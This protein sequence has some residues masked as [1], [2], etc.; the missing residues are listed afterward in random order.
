MHPTRIFV[1]V[2]T[3]SLL[4]LAPPAAVGQ[5]GQGALQSVGM[6]NVERASPSA[7][8]AARS[9]VAGPDGTGK[10]GP[11]AAVGRELAVLYYQNQTGGKQSVR[12]LREASLSREA[13]PPRTKR[14]RGERRRGGGGRVHSPISA[15]G[16]FVTVEATAARE[17]TRLLGDLEG[18]GL[19]GG[20]TAGNV[21]S[22]RLPISSIRAAAS[23][24]SLRG[25]RPSRAR[26]YVGSAESEADSAHRARST[27][28]NLGVN[29]RGQKVCALSDSY[30][31][32]NSAT[33]TASDD[34][35][36]GDL[37]GAENPSGRTAP[38][39]VLEDYDGSDPEPTDEGRA[40]LQLIHDIAPGARLG[41][42]TAFGGLAGFAQGIRDLA[43]AGC[44]VIVDDVGYSVEP[45]YQDGPVANAVDEVV[46]QGIPYFSSAGNDGENSYEAPFRGVPGRSGIIDDTYV[47]HDFNSGGATD[48]R[49]E[50]TIRPEGT[51]RI[52]SFQWTDPSAQVQGSAGP[53]TD[54]DIALVDGSDN[55]I[56]SSTRGNGVVPVESLE[57][58]NNQNTA[59]TL[60]LVVEKA[61]GDPTPDEIKYVYSGSGFSIEEYDTG[62]ATI[63]GHQMAEGAMAVAAAP[64]FNTSYSG[65]ID[66]SAILNFFS[67]KGGLKIRFDQNGDP[68]STPEP[69]EKPDVTGT[70]FIDNTFFGADIDIQDPDSFPNF[71]GTSA[72]A[73]NVAAIAALIR[74]ARQGLGP[75][76]VYDRLES[77]AVD[78]RVRQQ[79]QN[80]AISEELDPTGAGVDPWSGHG[81]VRADR[82]VPTPTGVQIADTGVEVSSSGSRSAEVAWQ[83][84]G[85]E[86]VDKFLLEKQYF[87]G[88]FVE[89]ERF[90]PDG[91]TEFVR[92]VENLPVGEHTFR[93]SALRNDSTL[94]RTRVGT[95]VRAEEI[96]VSAYPNPFRENVNLSVTLPEGRSDGVTVRVDVYDILG[97]RVATPISSREIGDS[98]S[99]SLGSSVTQ[100]LGS[101]VYF[102]RVWNEDFAATTKAVR[103][104]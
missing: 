92:T 88:A 96:S 63:Y 82:A 57:Y 43:N 101:G 50:I 68:L 29:G 5:D 48:T 8:T 60:D 99:L 17:A 75:E 36:S 39:D 2:L 3:G 45:F 44:T 53:D 16:Q 47:P 11:M 62:G 19:Q 21:V 51:F 70:D 20:A 9:A 102:F 55:V 64:F 65:Q 67:S 104:R 97:R 61:P 80:G 103:V 14:R 6:L 30:N 71:S 12:A 23:L 18:L 7:L 89:Q 73:P 58:T 22:G 84:A 74:E 98:Q 78:I 35:R 83:K 41:F 59:V 85:D 26:T 49:Q 93:I 77:T 34:I 86:R 27:R 25:M 69:R 46:A 95:V 15:D 38:V 33:T 42:H 37:P 24:S 91:N 28:E 54:I 4:A 94:A 1:V 81:F 87:E 76:S 90:S 72:A 31:Q 66:S 100:S 32:D 52:F 40:M 79:L 56:S 13:S 10:D